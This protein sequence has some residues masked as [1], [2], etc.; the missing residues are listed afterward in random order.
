MANGGLIT[1]Y[2]TRAAGPPSAYAFPGGSTGVPSLGSNSTETARYLNTTNNHE[3]AWDGAAWQDVSVATGVAGAMAQIA[4]VGP[5]GATQ[6]TADFPSIA[7]TYNHLR[8]VW[9]VYSATGT[10]FQMQI[11]ADSTAGNYTQLLAPATA[12]TFRA[13]IISSSLGSGGFVDIPNYKNT[14]FNKPWTGTHYRADNNTIEANAGY[15]HSTAAITRVTFSIDT[16]VFAVGS[17][18]TLYGTT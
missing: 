8:V 10:Y 11:N 9:Q 17:I 13:G 6:A 12:G 16:G 15:W 4:Q 7:G 14:T 2:M 3:Y 5:L 1:D 18:V